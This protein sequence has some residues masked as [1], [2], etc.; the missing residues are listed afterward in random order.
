MQY[1]WRKILEKIQLEFPFDD[2]IFLCFLIE[3]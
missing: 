2:H 3:S 1:K